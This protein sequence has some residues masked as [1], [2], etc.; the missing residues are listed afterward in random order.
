MKQITYVVNTDEAKMGWLL[1][2]IETLV[3][4]GSV[5]IFASQKAKTEEIAA[6]LCERGCRAAAIHGDK[7]QA[8]RQRIIFAFKNENID[9]LVATDMVSRGLDVKA[10]KTVVN[11]D[12][13]KNIESYVHRIGRTGRAGAQDGV[14]YT[15]VLQKE[16]NFAGQLV[17]CLEQVHQPV[18]KE[19][20]AVAQ[21]NPKFKTRRSGIGMGR[22][23]ADSDPAP[24]FGAE[25][26]AA[27]VKK[28]AFLSKFVKSSDVKVY[29]SKAEMYQDKRTSILPPSQ[30]SN[31]RRDS[32]PQPIQSMSQTAQSISRW[33]NN[34]YV[35][36]N[37]PQTSQSAS[38][39]DSNPHMTQNPP[40][41]TQGT[42]RWDSNP[43]MTQNP[44]QITQGTSRWDNPTNAKK[45][46]PKK[47][48]EEEIQAWKA[49]Y[50]L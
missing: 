31:S 47:S 43:H 19:L 16:T 23:Y 28:S 49:K 9:I 45:A 39:W 15:F 41:T 48:I 24:S 36:Q 50:G 20:L 10:V 2:N 46:E 13:P 30:A 6:K 18:P 38:R 42:S 1:K 26:Y 32:N 7:N 17:Q 35:T 44:P 5:L 22:T 8:E 12:T 3:G 37:P 29:S 4:S 33:D 11:Y 21:R 14:A 25:R 40:Q 27:P 34:S